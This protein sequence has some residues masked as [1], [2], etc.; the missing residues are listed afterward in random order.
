MIINQELYHVKKYVNFQQVRYLINLKIKIIKNINI[1][2]NHSYNNKNNNK[3][4]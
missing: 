3:L 1:I 4:N 2:S